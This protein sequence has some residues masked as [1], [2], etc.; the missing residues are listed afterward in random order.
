M[1]TSSIA[2]HQQSNGT[3]FA[4]FCLRLNIVYSSVC[5]L[6]RRPCQLYFSAVCSVIIAIHTLHI[7]KEIV[8][9]DL[10]EAVYNKRRKD[11]ARRIQQ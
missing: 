9:K 5:F 4:A 7:V 3:A 1:N 6:L 2:N 8:I 10:F 11:Y